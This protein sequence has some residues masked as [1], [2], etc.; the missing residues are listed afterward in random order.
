MQRERT[1]QKHGVGAEADGVADAPCAFEP[2]TASTSVAKRVHRDARL[3]R[4]GSGARGAQPRLR[5]AN[6]L[7][8]TGAALWRPTFRTAV[9]A[10]ATRA[11][12]CLQG[13]G[14][15]GQFPFPIVCSS[16]FFSA[17][18]RPPCFRRF[19]LRQGFGGR[20]GEAGPTLL[21]TCK[22]LIMRGDRALQ[23]FARRNFFLRA[24]RD[25][26][27]DAVRQT[28]AR[29]SV[30]LHRC[31]SPCRIPASGTDRFFRRLTYYMYSPLS[32]GLYRARVSLTREALRV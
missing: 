20:V 32:I 10:G 2:S 22:R 11:L 7:G 23:Q 25:R 15:P 17:Y 1:R 3:A 12:R 19:L 4:F 28:S 9:C 26:G 13:L 29:V 16:K 5:E 30:V 24:G 27:V 8:L 6:P 14:H 31:R 21:P 18:R